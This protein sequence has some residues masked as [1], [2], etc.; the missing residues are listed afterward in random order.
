M[1]ANIAKLPEPSRKPL[2]RSAA[3]GGADH[4]LMTFNRLSRSANGK[5]RATAAM[6]T[7]AFFM[8]PVIRRIKSSRLGEA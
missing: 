8:G 7:G 4:G 3:G 5:V 1:A 6:R 2:G